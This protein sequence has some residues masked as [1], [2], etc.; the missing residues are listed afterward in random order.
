MAAEIEI[1]QKNSQPALAIKAVTASFKLPMIIGKAYGRLM[2]YMQEKGIDM[3][4][5]PYTLYQDI[6]WQ[7]AGQSSGLK[8]FIAMFTYKWKMEIGVPVATDTAGEGEVISTTIPAGRYLKTLHRG[9]YAK[10]GDAY[11]RL[12]AH[13]S[14]QGLRLAPYS[15]E[16]YLNDPQTVGKDEL[17][18]EVLIALLD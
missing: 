15:L 10:I 4:G 6:D 11:N 14:E 12:T 3:S 8:A 9:P 18:T 1:V 2:S 13:A 16:L 7:Q 5:A 17:E